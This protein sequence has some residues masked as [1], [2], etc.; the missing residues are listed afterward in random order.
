MGQHRAGARRS[1]SAAKAQRSTAGA[2]PAP[3]AAAAG[4]MLRRSN[5]EPDLP[6]RRS[7]GWGRGVDSEDGDEEGEMW[8]VADPCSPEFGQVFADANVIAEAGVS[9]G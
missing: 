6:E 2:P 5:S 3:A 1:P 4:G 8:V 9:C 7:R